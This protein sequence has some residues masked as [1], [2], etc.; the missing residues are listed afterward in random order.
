MPLFCSR[1]FTA[2]SGWFW[3][4]SALHYSKEVKSPFPSSDSRRCLGFGEMKSLTR[5]AVAAISGNLGSPF[6]RKRSFRPAG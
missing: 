4:N 1:L 3:R 2:G 6:F 5:R